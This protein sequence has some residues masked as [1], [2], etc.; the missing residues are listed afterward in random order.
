M[1]RRRADDEGMTLIELLIAMAVMLIITTPLVT[2]FVLTLATT[3]TADQ[4]TTNSIDAQI[5]S[6]YFDRDVANSDS[7]SASSTCGAG[8]GSTTVLSSSWLDGATQ[9]IVAYQATADTPQQVALNAAH[10]YRV[11]RYDC[12]GGGATASV[13]ARSASVVPVALCDGAACTNIASTP[14]AV[15]LTINELPKKAGDPPFV[16]TLTA[17]RRVTS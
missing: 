8:G 4:D 7:I 5:I 17:T 3:S 14:S 15:T 9:H 2:G 11:T 13:V 6:S 12:T 1:R 10:V 16:L